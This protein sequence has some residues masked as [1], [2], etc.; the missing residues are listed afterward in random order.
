MNI[1][2]NVTIPDQEKY[3]N[4]EKEWEMRRNIADLFGVNED[5]IELEWEEEM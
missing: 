3:P 1:I 4:D 2:F 5:D